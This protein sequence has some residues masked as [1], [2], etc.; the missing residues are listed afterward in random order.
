MPRRRVLHPEEKE[1]W[2]AVARTARSLHKIPQ[3]ERQAE[4]APLPAVLPPPPPALP[5]RFRIGEKAPA[6]PRLGLPAPAPLQMDAKTHARM[7]RGKLAPEARIDLHGMTVPE[8]HA[9]LIAFVL[10]ARAS[11][12]RLLLVI[13]GKGAR[14]A[15]TGPIPQRSG[16]LRQQAPQWLRLPP[17]GHAVLQITQAHQRHGGAGALYVYLRRG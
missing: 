17:L 10:N 4:P 11:G 16:A 12:Q 6:P 2:L 5:Q 14:G 3:P 7:S 1:L 13:T 9:A 8:A 15:D